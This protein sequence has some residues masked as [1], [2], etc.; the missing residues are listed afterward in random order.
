MEQD[1]AGTVR[2]LM[3][4]AEAAADIKLEADA[5][6]DE[7]REQLVG[8]GAISPQ[9]AKLS[10]QIIPAYVTVKAK[11]TGLGVREIYDM[12]GLKIQGNE[13]GEAITDNLFGVM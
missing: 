9:N 5:V 10:A 4:R 3:S 6:Y 7:V 8:T 2:D 13:G 1:Q 12:M 11:E